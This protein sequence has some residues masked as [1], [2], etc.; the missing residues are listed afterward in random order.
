MTS[1]NIFKLGNIGAVMVSPPLVGSVLSLPVL[2]F[3]N[4]LLYRD[5]YHDFIA[6]Y[7]YAVRSIALSKLILSGAMIGYSLRD[8]DLYYTGEDHKCYNGP[9][10]TPCYDSAKV[11][12][13]IIGQVMALDGVLDLSIKIPL[14]DFLSI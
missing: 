7:K 1:R 13:C 8:G 12:N 9:Q 4:I 14:S 11:S 10:E 2:M 6:D 5:S 3:S